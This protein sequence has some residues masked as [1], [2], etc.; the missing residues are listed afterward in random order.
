MSAFNAL[1]NGLFLGPI[2]AM[3]GGRLLHIVEVCIIFSALILG[4][5]AFL[6]VPFISSKSYYSGVF[7]YLSMIYILSILALSVSR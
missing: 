1:V 4:M 7:E 6:A 5:Q 2:S 3:F